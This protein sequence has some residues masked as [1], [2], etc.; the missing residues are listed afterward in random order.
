MLDV[1]NTRYMAKPRRPKALDLVIQTA[2]IRQG[3]VSATALH[4]V[5]AEHGITVSRSAVQ[6]WW[7]AV[8][9]PRAEYLPI[10]A[11]ILDVPLETLCYAAVPNRQVRSVA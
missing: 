4:A 2:A 3:I 1:S 11:G 7:T 6:H 9:R 8:D 5:C 10:L